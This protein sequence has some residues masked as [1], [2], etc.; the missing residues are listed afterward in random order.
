MQ[1]NFNKVREW[2]S[3]IRKQTMLLDRQIR[4]IQREEAKVKVSLKQAAKKGDRDVCVILAKEIVGSRKAINRINTSKAQLNSVALHMTQQSANLRVAGAMQKSSEV[5][6][7]MNN[8]MKVTEISATMQELSREMMRAGIMEEMM[9]ETLD[10]VTGIDE[11]EMEEEIQAEVDKVLFEITQ[12]TKLIMICS[13][14]TLLQLYTVAFLFDHVHGIFL[15][16]FVILGQIGKAPIAVADSLPATSVA[17][18]TVADAEDE[19]EEEEMVEMQKRLQALKS[20]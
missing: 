9:E 2:T 6:K 7:T 4:N 19:D 16:P 12:G 15:S 10:E 11:E 13:T 20:T 5:M 18:A 8:L 1:Y 17:S 3:K 14:F